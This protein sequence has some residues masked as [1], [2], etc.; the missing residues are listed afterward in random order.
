MR[1]LAQRVGTGEWLHRDLPLSAVERTRTLSG[2]STIQA[3]L[4]PGLRH[5]THTDGLRIL[6]DWGTFIYAAQTDRNGR[7]G[8]IVCA[9]IYIDAT[10]EGDTQQFTA[11]GFATYPHGTIFEDARLWG[12]DVGSGT[13]ENPEKP[14]PDPLQ[15]VQDHWAW[16][17]SM[18]DADLGVRVV[19]DLASSERIGDYE[20]PYRL[21]WWEMPD[22][23]A[24]IDR[25]AAETPFDYVEEHEWVD[26][27]QQEVD[28]RIRIGWPRIGRRRDDLRFAEGENII[29]PLTGPS[30]GASSGNNIIGIGNG[31]GAKMV[32]SRASV[33]NG[34]LR[35]TVVVTDKTKGQAEMDN[36]V[37]DLAGRLQP[38]LDIT[39]V[40]IKDHRNARISAIAPGDDILVQGMLPSYGQGSMWVRVLAITEN[41]DTPGQAVLTTKRSSSFL[42]ST[43]TEVSGQ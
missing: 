11:P 28:H 39:S 16:I 27:T 36:L 15:I 22:L 29:V 21:Q 34:R 14:R 30:T 10:Y 3:T 19:G 43:T 2:P 31:E 23:G 35:R 26:E 40:A 25:L 8:P 32:Q 1:Y 20:A 7:T 5:A 17:Q 12:P 18:P 38:T 37:R 6:E 13:E 4:T 9:G 41:D 24:E 33:R 42:Y